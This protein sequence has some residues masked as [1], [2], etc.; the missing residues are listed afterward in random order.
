MVESVDVYCNL[1]RFSQIV[2]KFQYMTDTS[3]IRKREKIR[4]G[5]ER[6]AKGNL[7]IQLHLKC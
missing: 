6:G 2:V 4:E 7:T 5:E 3:S 1:F